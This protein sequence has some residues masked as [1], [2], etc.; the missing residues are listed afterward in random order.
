MPGWQADISR[1]R[2][3]AELPAA[4]RA[5][6]ERVEALVGV[7]CRWIGVGPGRDALWEGLT[8]SRHASG[9]GVRAATLFGKACPARSVVPSRAFPEASRSQQ[10]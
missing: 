9:G 5:Y 1:V 2:T 8:R 6:V 4:A 3:Y 7:E 10:A